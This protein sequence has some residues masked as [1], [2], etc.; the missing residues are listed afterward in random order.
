MGLYLLPVNFF[1]EVTDLAV[2]PAAASS[3]YSEANLQLISRDVW[4]SVN[5][6]SHVFTG[7]WGGNMRVISAFGVWPSGSV[8][9]LIGSSWRLELFQD[10]AATVSLFDQTYAF[11]TPAGSVWGSFSWGA[12]PWGV[13]DGDRTARLAPM[14]KYFSAVNASAFRI[15]VTDLHYVDTPYFEARRI[16]LANYVQAP[17]NATYG[18]APEWAS[19]STQR[20]TIGGALRR[21]ARAR[22]RAL[23]FETMFNSEADRAVWSDLMYACDPSN[24]IV[25]SL[26]PTDTNPRLVRDYTVMGSLE[27]INPHV[28]DSVNYHTLK[29]A[30]VES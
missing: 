26:F 12:T 8:S 13:E 10:A 23:R 29:L 7:A 22:W 4:R 19:G 24:E 18:A 21:N 5:L 20:R 1:A 14:V 25:I 27:V 28:F 9:S 11:F 15:T 6:S 3:S 30:I 17:F 16:W 2:S